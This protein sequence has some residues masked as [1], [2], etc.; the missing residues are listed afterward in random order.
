MTRIKRCSSSSRKS[1]SLSLSLFVRS[2]W[3]QVELRCT[4]PI[5]DG[6]KYMCCAFWGRHAHPPRVGSNSCTVSVPSYILPS[7]TLLGVIV[8]RIVS[9]SPLFQHHEHRRQHRWYQCCLPVSFC[10]FFSLIAFLACVAALLGA[11][12]SMRGGFASTVPLDPSTELPVGWVG[13]S[14]Q[15]SLQLG[16]A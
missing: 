12:Y 3:E 9:F 5:D 16:K 13:A 6:V 14:C 8:F 1:L 4:L 11:P 7:S 10:S 2:Y 15:H